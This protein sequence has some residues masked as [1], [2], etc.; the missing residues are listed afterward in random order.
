MLSELIVNHMVST[1]AA[2]L[3]VP[4]GDSVAEHRVLDTARRQLR[5]IFLGSSLWPT[6]PEP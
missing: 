4:A 1:A 6:P 2:L 3:D 5:L